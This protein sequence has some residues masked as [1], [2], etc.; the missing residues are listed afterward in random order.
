DC[1]S[2]HSFPTRR[3]SD[4]DYADFGGVGGQVVGTE[5]EMDIERDYS[6]LR[7]EVGTGDLGGG[8][9]D[10]EGPTTDLLRVEL[11]EPGASDGHVEIDRKSTRLNSSHVSIS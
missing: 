6:W 8:S 5:G 11:V 7:G 4:L 2:L 9:F 3:S 10:D 1:S